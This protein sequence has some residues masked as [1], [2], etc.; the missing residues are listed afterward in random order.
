MPKPRF[1]DPVFASNASPGSDVMAIS[2]DFWSCAQD[3]DGWHSIRET[4]RYMMY[5]EKSPVRTSLS[6]LAGLLPVWQ[7]RETGLT[8]LQLVQGQQPC[9]TGEIFF[10]LLDIIVV[11]TGMMRNSMKEF[12]DNVIDTSVI[13]KTLQVLQVRVPSFE[14]ALSSG[15]PL[16]GLLVILQEGLFKLGRLAAHQSYSLVRHWGSMAQVCEEAL[17][18]R[19]TL[20]N[21]LEADA[22]EELLPLLPIGTRMLATRLW[23]HLVS[24]PELCES[25]PG[26]IAAARMVASGLLP[27]QPLSW[28]ATGWR[29]AY[30]RLK[31]SLDHALQATSWHRLLFSG[32][33]L[34]AILHRL[35]EAY[36]REALCRDVDRYAYAIPSLAEPQSVWVC[37]RRE[38]D[39]VDERWRMKGSFPDCGHIVRAVRETLPESCTFV[40]VGANLGGCTLMLGKD[41]YPVLAIEVV[42]TLAKLLNASVKRNSLESVEV[43]EVA[44]GATNAAGALHCSAGHSAI[45]HVLPT[46]HKAETEVATMSLDSILKMRKLSPCAIKIDV[47][48]SELEVLKGAPE[49]LRES[50]PSLFLELHPYELRERGSS[51][52]EVFDIVIEHGYDMFERPAC[53]SGP[54]EERDLWRGNGTYANVRW[55]R[56]EPLP[57]I[58]LPVV[59]DHC[60]CEQECHLRLLPSN[61]RFS[62]NCRCW[63][64][65]SASG[66]C[67]LYRRCGKQLH[68]A[69]QPSTGWWAGELTGNWHIF[70]KGARVG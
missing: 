61:G 50:Q 58:R 21:W 63:D 17:P 33:P 27:E 29:Q 57:S 42:P 2:A 8:D 9:P 55:V 20:Q 6:R 28:N 22:G 49:T 31:S 51:S 4:A 65:N 16:F 36:V 64:F 56:A 13:L 41:G 67:T 12:D 38:A 32:W 46:E 34:L 11:N 70:R 62:G 39:V 18:L 19:A 60:S 40:D 15:W 43:L 5:E 59:P 69:L 66:S 7:S 37:V 23:R 25:E 14:A 3:G 45:C 68:D 1:V 44:V 48:G 35:Q 52:A 47:E 24:M 30:S 10:M 54:L 26:A 53:Q